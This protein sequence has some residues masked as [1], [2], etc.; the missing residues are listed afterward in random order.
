MKLIPI[1]LAAACLVAA[2]P[3]AAQADPELERM[4]ES[5]RPMIGNASPEGAVVRRIWAD[6]R[7]MVVSVEAPA[8]YERTPAWIANAVA[9]GICSDEEGRAFLAGG[10]TI[11]I[12][13][14]KAG[15]AMESA[16][17]DVCGVPPAA[18]DG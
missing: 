6:G 12:E 4:I 18:P 13:I 1:M 15:G 10:H 16:T 9:I 5:Y 17:R 14:T 2:V 7:I 8:S 3:A 11:R